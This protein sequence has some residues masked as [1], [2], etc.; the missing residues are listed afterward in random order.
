M[1]EDSLFPRPLTFIICRLFDDGHSDQQH[2][3]W[4][5]I[6]VLICICQ[7][8]RGLNIFRMFIFMGL[9][10]YVLMKH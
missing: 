2:V 1:Y 10:H 4:Y 3:R 8:I 7:I 9:T 5:L 6:V